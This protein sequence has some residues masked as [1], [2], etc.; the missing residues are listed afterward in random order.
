MTL[1]VHP[2]FLGSWGLYDFI[3]KNVTKILNDFHA[4]FFDLA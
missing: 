4:V 2:Q 1:S 3:K